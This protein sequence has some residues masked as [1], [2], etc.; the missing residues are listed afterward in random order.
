MKK[1]ERSIRKE[2]S[3]IGPGLR[4]GC[5]SLA[6]H[7]V[8]I[9]PSRGLVCSLYCDVDESAGIVTDIRMYATGDARERRDY[10][11]ESVNLSDALGHYLMQSSQLTWSDFVHEI[12]EIVQNYLDDEPEDGI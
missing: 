2:L 9:M 1:L 5:Y 4:A 3:H 10:Y 11:N 12:E 8:G 6:G 7:Y